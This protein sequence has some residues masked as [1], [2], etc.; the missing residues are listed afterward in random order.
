MKHRVGHGHISNASLCLL[1]PKTAASKKHLLV[2]LPPQWEMNSW[3]TSL[4]SKGRPKERLLAL[5]FSSS[6]FSLV[7]MWKVHTCY[8][9]LSMLEEGMSKAQGS[10]VPYPPGSCWV[11]FSLSCPSP[12]CLA[13]AWL[14]RRVWQISSY[15][16]GYGSSES[17]LWE[18]AH[19]P[20]D[21]FITNG[22][23]RPKVSDGM[24]HKSS[25]EQVWQ[26][27]SSLDLLT[28]GVPDESPSAGAWAIK[29]FCARYK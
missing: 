18:E 9:G 3:H 25:L 4:R 20:V 1:F 27:L 11:R 16:A 28:T 23:T 10:S 24:P 14:Y 5:P 21:V 19:F 17:W 2:L 6:S 29:N 8:C 26:E 7:I 22:E 15:L 13:L 12:A